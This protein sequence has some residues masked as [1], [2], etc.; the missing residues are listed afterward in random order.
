LIVAQAEYSGASCSSCTA[1]DIV[2]IARVR[3]A[4]V[5]QLRHS[6]T[7]VGKSPRCH[8]VQSRILR[9]FHLQQ[10]ISRDLL[11]VVSIVIETVHV[12][13]FSV[14]SDQILE[15]IAI[16]S[17]IFDHTVHFTGVLGNIKM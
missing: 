3:M 8:P 16:K 13:N 12:I 9:S 11:S 4:R 2:R 15:F 7:L 1:P 17:E 14:S 5:S 10:E 6:M